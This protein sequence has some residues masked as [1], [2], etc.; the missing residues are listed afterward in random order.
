ML[1]RADF[2][3]IGHAVGSLVGGVA[4]DVV[5][6]VAHAV[7]TAVGQIVATV[8]TLWVH[9]PTPDL[10]S[11]GCDP[12]SGPCQPSDTVGFLQGDL[13]WLTVAVAAVSIAVGASRWVSDAQKGEQA[14]RELLGGL[15]RFVVVS[16]L[17]VTLIWML[18][19]IGDGFSTW[20][21]NQSLQCVTVNGQRSCS[22]FGANMTVLLGFSSATAVGLGWGMVVILLGLLAFVASMIQVLLMYM[23]GGLL[24]LFAGMLPLVAANWSTE[25]GRHQYKRGIAWTSAA[26]LYKPAAAIVY[27]GA[28]RLAGQNAFAGGGAIG[29]IL[30]GL[31]MMIVALVALPALVRFIAPVT[32]AVA[33]G[34]MGGIL[35]G[36]AGY[37]AMRAGLPTGAEGDGAVEAAMAAGGRAG[38]GGGG[39]GPAGADAVDSGGGPLP[40]S[41][42]SSSNSNGNGNGDGGGGG[43]GGGSS[44]GGV[45]AAGASGGGTAAANGGGSAAGN[46]GGAGAQVGSSS[47]GTGAALSPEAAGAAMMNGLHATFTGAAVHGA[48]DGLAGQAGEREE[49]PGGARE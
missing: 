26:V 1:Q 37:G 10:V 48:I 38:G 5:S 7:F 24:V 4:G 34:G 28:F 46:G 3:G 21:I 20:I 32:S 25:M 19:Q 39:A 11:S 29:S 8:A 14:G 30:S 36:V 12:S 2:L 35:A 47:G 31:T 18:V 42:G 41:G 13:K 16:G 44:G 23:R 9:V 17:G 22:D 6:A 33:G 27:A 45:M 49:G 15:V 43:G 40:P